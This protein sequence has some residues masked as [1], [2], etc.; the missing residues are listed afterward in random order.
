V[1]EAA[2]LVARIPAAIAELDLQDAVG[3]DL[4]IVDALVHHTLTG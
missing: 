4:D 3:A 1:L 2:A